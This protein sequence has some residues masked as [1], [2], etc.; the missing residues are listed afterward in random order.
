MS[1]DPP[2]TD[3][4]GGFGFTDVPVAVVPTC[5]AGD[6]VCPEIS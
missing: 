2:V 1:F 6:V 5:G 4:D 3:T